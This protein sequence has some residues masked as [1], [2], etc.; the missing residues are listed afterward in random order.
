M[1]KGALAL[2]LLK[3]N[4]GREGIA[5]YDLFIIQEPTKEADTRIVNNRWAVFFSLKSPYFFRKTAPLIL[6]SCPL[7]PFAAVS[8]PAS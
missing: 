6:Q 7:T 4:G 3:A 1:P 5:A 8:S 2:S